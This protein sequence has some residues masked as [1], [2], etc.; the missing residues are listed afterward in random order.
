MHALRILTLS[1]VCAA[2]FVVSA[3][4]GERKM[5]EL[6]YLYGEDLQGGRIIFED[7]SSAADN[8]LDSEADVKLQRR[9]KIRIGE[10]IVASTARTPLL[11]Q[12]ARD[13]QLAGRLF[14]PQYFQN[15]ASTRTVPSRYSGEPEGVIY[16]G[17]NEISQQANGYLHFFI[18]QRLGEIVVAEIDVSSQEN[19]LVVIPSDMINV[20]VEGSPGVITYYRGE[21]GTFATTMRWATNTHFYTLYSVQDIKGKGLISELVEFAA[22]IVPPLPHSNSDQ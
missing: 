3:Q 7:T 22:A 16:L 4:D 17:V 5:Q 1:I 2:S 12:Q 18:S 21:D 10:Y 14:P 6:R 15:D 13:L 9:A 11:L 8:N 19:M 20:N